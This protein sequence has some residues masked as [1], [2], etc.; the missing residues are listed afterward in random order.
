MKTIYYPD[1]DILVIRL[2][3][4]PVVKEVSQD[5]N[6]NISYTADGSIAEVVILEAAERG[7]YP[8]VTEEQA[9]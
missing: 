5:W 4:A 9:A 8:V 7:L 3:D 2:N 6:V 1:D